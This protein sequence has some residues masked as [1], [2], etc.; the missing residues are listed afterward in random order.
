MIVEVYWYWHNLLYWRRL[1]ESFLGNLINW[2]VKVNK[3]CKF[4]GCR[5]NYIYRI[6][7]IT[8][9]RYFHKLN[10]TNTNQKQWLT[11]TFFYFI[12]CINFHCLVAYF[13]VK[14]TALFK[15]SA[16]DL[17][18]SYQTKQVKSNESAVSQNN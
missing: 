14:K 12:A 8:D 17:F 18:Y 1:V 5:S 11:F 10:Q 16:M 9:S 15:E 13:V 7:K 2:T 3:G 4:L 6:T